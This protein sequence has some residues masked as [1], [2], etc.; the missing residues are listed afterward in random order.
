VGPSPIHGQGLFSTVPVRAG[1]VVC[2]AR[3][4]DM[5]TPGGR[6]IN[7]AKN[8]NAVMQQAG[9]GDMAVVALRDIAGAHGGDIGEEI[10]VDYRQAVEAGRLP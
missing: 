8:P 9:G 5:R 2:P 6:Y 4:G 7:H 10:T 3:I 1:E